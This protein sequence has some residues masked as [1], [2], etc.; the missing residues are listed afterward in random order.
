MVPHYCARVCQMV[1]AACFGFAAQDQLR[2]ALQTL[3]S[4]LLDIL[5][6]SGYLV[7]ETLDNG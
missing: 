2:F 4:G 1:S 3:M 6:W 5:V 7:A